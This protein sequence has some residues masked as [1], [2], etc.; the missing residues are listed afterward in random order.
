ME[1]AKSQKL[2]DGEIRRI[3]QSACLLPKS[4]MLAYGRASETERIWVGDEGL[5]NLSRLKIQS[6]PYG[7]IGDTVRLFELKPPHHSSVIIFFSWILHW[8]NSKYKKN[9]IQNQK[10]T[11]FY[12][13]FL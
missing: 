2:G 5:S 1:L 13:I 11:Y 9:K 6:T 3:G 4:D 10:Y 7:N 8:L 12:K